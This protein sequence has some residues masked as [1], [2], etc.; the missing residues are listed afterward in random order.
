MKLISINN[1]KCKLKVSRILS[2]KNNTEA[3]ADTN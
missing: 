1:G 3:D 2:T